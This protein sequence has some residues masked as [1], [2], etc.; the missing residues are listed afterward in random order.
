MLTGPHN[1][2][3]LVVR[4]LFIWISAIVITIIMII[5]IMIIS[6]T[7]TS[8]LDYELYYLQMMMII[9]KISLNMIAYR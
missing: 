4:L 6:S 9:I 1:Y 2:Y 7:H 5:I 3:D 8:Y